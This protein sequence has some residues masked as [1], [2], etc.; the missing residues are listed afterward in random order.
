MWQPGM[1]GSETGGRNNGPHVS[2]IEDGA[3][4]RTAFLVRSPALRENPYP[5]PVQIQERLPGHTLAA[6]RGRLDAVGRV[7]GRLHGPPAEGFD[8]ARKLMAHFVDWN[9]VR[10]SR[11][12]TLVAVLG[13]QPRAPARIALLQRFL[14][15][16][17]LRQRNPN[18]EFLFSLKP[19]EVRRFIALQSGAP[20]ALAENAGERAPKS[21]PSLP[22]P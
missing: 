17:F 1:E 8:A 19:L 10:V 21:K 11:P 5:T 4:D 7:V 13:R 20:A 9:E 12:A 2:R 15:V 14:E 6:S 22:T 16:Y 3:V 18:L